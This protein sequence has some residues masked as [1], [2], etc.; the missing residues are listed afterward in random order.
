MIEIETYSKEG[1]A[2]HA[3]LLEEW[4]RRDYIHYPYLWMPTPPEET[5]TAQPKVEPAPPRL[6]R[7]FNE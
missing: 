2:T 6:K 3:F 5:A 1:I 7:Y 4:M